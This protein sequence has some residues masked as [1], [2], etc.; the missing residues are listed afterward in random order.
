[1]G[2]EIKGVQRILGN[3]TAF[4]KASEPDSPLLKAAMQRAALLVVNQTQLNI[5]KQG[6][7][8]T[9]ALFNSIR[10]KFVRTDT[11]KQ[12][13][14][15]GSFGIPYAAVWEGILGTR[16]KIPRHTRV[17]N[18]VWGRITKQPVVQTVGGHMRTVTPRPFLRP[19]L[20]R[21]RDKVSQIISAALRGSV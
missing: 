9:G 6:L 14:A 1:M 5:R 20:Q 12:A 19:A 8:D 7:I 10:S 13:I 11:N 2:V 16:I 4:A 17:V 3:L 21:H 15:I 18:K